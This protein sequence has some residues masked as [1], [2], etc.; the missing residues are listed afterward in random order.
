MKKKKKQ[1]GE[2]DDSRVEPTQVSP[3]AQ[4]IFSHAP[5]KSKAV[6]FLF[7]CL[8]DVSFFLFQDSFI[9]LFS[10]FFSTQLLFQSDPKMF[11]CMSGAWF[12]SVL[13]P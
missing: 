1:G 2:G 9:S 8:Q 13:P 3:S 10:L 11:S 7:E 4:L 12:Q 6:K 5:L